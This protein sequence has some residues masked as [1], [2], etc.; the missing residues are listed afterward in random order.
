MKKLLDVP[1]R[2]RVAASLLYGGMSLFLFG[3]VFAVVVRQ[4]DRVA[5]YQA[6]EWVVVAALIALMVAAGAFCALVAW[7]ALSDP[8]SGLGAWVQKWPLVDS[9]FY[10]AS[11]A[12]V[13]GGIFLVYLAGSYD[14]FMGVAVFFCWVLFLIWI[15]RRAFKHDGEAFDGPNDEP[16]ATD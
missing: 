3:V 1:L 11:E 7:G 12:F 16:R 5:A 10:A 2:Y 8:K 13:W 15:L 9:V 4:A 6:W 14:I